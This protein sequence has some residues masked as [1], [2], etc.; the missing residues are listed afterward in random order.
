MSRI[1]TNSDD[2]NKPRIERREVTSFFEKRAEKIGQ[3][4]PVRA[5][6]Y[7]D[8]HPDLAERRDLHEKRRI[9]PLLALD[10]SQRLLDV[11]CGTGRWAYE[12]AD[13]CE[14]YH[15]IDISEG[16]ITYAA[17]HSRHRNCRFTVAPVD[18][19]T[20]AALGETT[21]FDRVLC[22]G[23]LIY[24]NDDEAH[25]AL[26]CI[27]ATMANKARA[28]FREPMGIGRRLTIKEHYS[29]D[30]DQSYNAIYRTEEEISDLMQSTL[31]NSGFQLLAAGDVFEAGDLNN[32][33]ETRQRWLLLERDV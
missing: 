15:G 17:E 3:L 5:V 2:P 23:V 1:Q 6:I 26:R 14:H 31:F 18:D 28:V 24:L 9:G 20:L 12:V 21:P 16:L 4:G 32:R 33:A 10:G 8:K 7:Q 11:G 22:A 30:M 25:R 27:G 19:F 29:D 13:A